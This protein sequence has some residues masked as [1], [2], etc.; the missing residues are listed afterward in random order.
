MAHDIEARVAF[1]HR[2]LQVG[3]VLVVAK[4]NVVARLVRLDEAVLEHEGLALG[5]RD[6][7]IDIDN[8][9]DEAVEPRALDPRVQEVR[10][11]P[12]SKGAGFADIEDLPTLPTE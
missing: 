6:D 4:K 5:I 2:E 8:A 9:L 11:H 7:N 3:M 10:A 1:V 12:A